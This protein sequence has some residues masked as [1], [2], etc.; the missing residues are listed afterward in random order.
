[1]SK[2]EP[3]YQQNVAAILC[4]GEGKILVCERLQ[5]PGAW[6]F[7]QGGVDE[8]ETVEKALTRELGEEIGLEPGDFRI[9]EKKAGYRYLFPSGQRRGHDG[10]DQTYF[11]CALLADEKKINIE[12]AHPEFRACKWIF[13]QEFRR[14]WLPKM[15]LGV[16][17]AV[18]QDFFGVTI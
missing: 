11:F 4:N 8:G 2:T 10:K 7:P 17:S 1:M 5:T 18:F 6:Q 15:K 9:L 14:D 13:P 12:T 16:Y 3:N